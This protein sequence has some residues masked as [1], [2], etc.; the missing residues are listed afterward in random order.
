MGNSW[1][2]RENNGW[3]SIPKNGERGWELSLPVSRKASLLRMIHYSDREKMTQRDAEWTALEGPEMLRGYQPWITLPASMSV[4]APMSL[5]DC[6]S[7]GSPDILQEGRQLTCYTYNQQFPP[8]SQGVSLES[9]QQT[10]SNF[11]SLPID[12]VMETTWIVDNGQRKAAFPLSINQSIKP[13]NCQGAD[14]TKPNILYT[15]KHLDSQQA[16]HTSQEVQNL[17]ASPGKDI[18]KHFIWI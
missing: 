12:Q 16:W 13:R 8:Y 17:K 9:R 14:N 11:L 6:V 7:Q 3:Q 18:Y 10:I 2:K 15:E 1:L 4:S 5:P